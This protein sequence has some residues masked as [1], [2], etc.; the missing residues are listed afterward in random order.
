MSSLPPRRFW[1]RSRRALGEEA[2][3]FIRLLARARGATA[4]AAAV[5]S[6]AQAAWVLRWSGLISVVAQ[7]ALTATFL[8]LPIRSELGV[9]GMQ[10]LLAD[11]RW[12]EALQPSRLPAPG[13]E[14][15]QRAA[16][17]RWQLCNGRRRL[18]AA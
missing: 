13:L 15:C 18:R 2:A 3:T 9:A 5:R 6:S 4:P 14:R 8:E 7:L 17:C 16:A 10:E 12:R 1:A 11:A